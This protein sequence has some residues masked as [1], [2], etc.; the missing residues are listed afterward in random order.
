MS[1]WGS[2]LSSIKY[3]FLTLTSGSHGNAPPCTSIQAQVN[4]T[5]PMIMTLVHKRSI[6][7][8]KCLISPSFLP[9]KDGEASSICYAEPNK[10]KIPALEQLSSGS[11][12]RRGKQLWG[13]A[14]LDVGSLFAIPLWQP[15]YS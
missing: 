15:M 6:L 2:P 5:S 11:I 3:W 8:H 4:T 12:P 14:I 1:Q 7:V 10:L 9:L 13:T